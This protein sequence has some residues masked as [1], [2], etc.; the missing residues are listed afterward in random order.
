MFVPVAVIQSAPIS[1]NADASWQRDLAAFDAELAQRKAAFASKHLSSERKEDVKQILSHLNGL[2]QMRKYVYVPYEHGYG[3]TPSEQAFLAAFLPRMKR[4]DEENL[5]TFKALLD[6]WGWFDKTGWGKKADDEAWLL[7]DH[8]DGD[9]AFQTRVLGL[10]DPLV[11]SGET[12]PSHFAYLFD[13]VAV[14]G[15]RLQRFGTQG[16]CIGPGK[17]AP[18]PIE[19]PEHV[20]ARRKAVGLSP[21]AEYIA[22]FQNIC[23]EDETQR[24]LQ[25]TGLPIK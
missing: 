17:W 24:A 8:A 20:D 5:R 15:R 22:S 13:R 7:A 25:A 9:L 12:D 18:R 3:G 2:D 16:Y 4:L 23:R 11:K 10:L 14:N 21:L 6:R 1:A 19:D